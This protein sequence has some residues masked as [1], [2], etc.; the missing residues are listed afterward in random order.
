MNDAIEYLNGSKFYC[1]GC[2]K[3]KKGHGYLYN[4]KMQV[5]E[6]HY[7]ILHP[8]IK[9]SKGEF[10]AISCRCIRCV[11]AGEKR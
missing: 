5:C 1:E 9:T 11:K 10:H 6:K 8:V 2:G 7:S 4:N 3:M